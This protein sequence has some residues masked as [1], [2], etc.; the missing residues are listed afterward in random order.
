MEENETLLI[1]IDE[2]TKSMCEKI[3]MI[4]V[5]NEKQNGLLDKDGKRITILEAKQ[6]GKRELVLIVLWCGIIATTVIAFVK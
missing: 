2:R 6:L 3:D 4:L 1:R 5:H